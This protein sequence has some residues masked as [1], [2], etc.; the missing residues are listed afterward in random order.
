MTTKIYIIIFL[1]LTSSTIYSQNPEWMIYNTSLIKSFPNDNNLSVSISKNEVS[2]AQ[3]ADGTNKLWSDG[4]VLS[5][6]INQGTL[7]DNFILSLALDGKGNLW[8]GTNAGLAKFDGEKWIVYNTSNSGLTSNTIYSVVI[9]DNRDIWIGTTTGLVKFDENKWIVYNTSNSG[10]PNNVIYS[11]AIDKQSSMWIGTL[12]GLTKFDGIKWI[13]FNTKNSRLPDNN[14]TALLID[15]NDNKWIGTFSGLAKFDGYSWKVYKTSNSGLPYNDVYSISKAQH[16]EIFVQTW[17]GGLAKYNGKKW[18][19][20]NIKNSSLPD[21]NVSSLLIDEKGNRWI[22]TLAGFVKFDGKKWTT[23]NT[24][25]S[26]LPDNRIYFLVRDPNGNIWIGTQNGLAVFREGGIISLPAE[27]TTFN[28]EVR[29]NKVLLNWQSA[30][31]TNIYG[32]EIE[33]EINNSGWS[34]IGFIRANRNT[35]SPKN[36]SFVDTNPR[37]GRNLYRIK[38]IDFYSYQK[39]SG[40]IAADIY[41]PNNFSLEQIIDNNYNPIKKIKLS[42]PKKTYVKVTIKDILGREISEL[43]NGVLESGY[44]EISFDGSILQSG[45]YFYQIYA[46]NIKQIQ[47]MVVLK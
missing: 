47:K 10:L 25:N 11:I 15:E 46:G 41:L 17:G 26:L 44:H 1:F 19:R 20:Y 2:H 14:I 42:L 16:G 9:D 43:I 30:S 7:P 36:Y 22:G 8:A 4:W 39:F 45:I 18:N 3:K 6:I 29:L 5:N 37:T 24:S 35:N 28:S 21:N 33:K 31:E 40:I 12:G 23:F 38:Q 34:K 27:I 13:T 32:F